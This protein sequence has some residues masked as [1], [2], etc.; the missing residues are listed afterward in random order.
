MVLLT[1]NAMIRLRRHSAPRILVLT[2]FV[3]MLAM[4][5]VTA[6]QLSRLASGQSTTTP[7]TSMA[8]GA[9][10]DRSE[11]HTSEL[12]SQSNLVCRLLLEKKKTQVLV[13]DVEGLNILEFARASA[14]FRVFQVRVKAVEAFV[15]LRLFINIGAEH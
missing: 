11:E 10:F 4:G 7:Q 1:K 3:T 14:H 5:I 6:S 12:Q 15:P 2:L 8:T 9:Y 13:T